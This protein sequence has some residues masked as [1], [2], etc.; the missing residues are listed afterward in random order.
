[1]T[2]LEVVPDLELLAEDSAEVREFI[3]PLF[4]PLE[5]DL[6]KIRL[7][8]KAELAVSEFLGIAQLLMREGVPA[9]EQEQ[10]LTVLL[11]EMILHAE[12]RGTPAALAVLRTLAAI[13]PPP[14][15]QLAGHVA[16]K[17]AA[18][19]IPDRKWAAVVGH[20]KIGRCWRY[21]NSEGEQ[22]SVTATFLYGHREHAVSVL[23]DHVL[24]GGIKD[25]W[26]TDE[27]EILWQR[28]RTLPD[29][30]PDALI[31]QLS[32]SQAHDRFSAALAVDPCPV[33]DDQIEDLA[34]FMPLLRA[35]MALSCAR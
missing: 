24:G 5:M 13:G 32:W 28:T 22:E 35:R 3:A 25:C 16:A 1:V 17:M 23:I 26:V 10:A 8:L 12:R 6:R 27:A 2:D 9:G 18:G 33:D 34:C 11:S 14:A 30:E 7:A 4:A 29:I 31:E 21:A 19:G 20:P 15:A